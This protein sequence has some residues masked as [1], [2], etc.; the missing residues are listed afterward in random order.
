MYFMRILNSSVARFDLPN[1]GVRHVQPHTFYGRLL[2]F[3][4]TLA[5]P[6]FAVAN[7]SDAEMSVY[8]S[9]VLTPSLIFLQL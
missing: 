7:F 6:H 4:K 9:P 5:Q 3:D 1:R 2:V 8:Y